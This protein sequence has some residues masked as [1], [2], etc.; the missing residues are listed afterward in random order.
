MT[1]PNI[2]ELSNFINSLTL[3]LILILVFIQMLVVLVVPPEKAEKLNYLGKFLEY[4][5]KV[6]FPGG[7]NDRKNP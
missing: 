2:T 7:S 3:L 4:L 6:R 1:F 5:V